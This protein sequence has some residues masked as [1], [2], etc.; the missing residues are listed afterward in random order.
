MRLAGCVSGELGSKDL[1]TV[2][3][4]HFWKGLVLKLVWTHFGTLMTHC[5]RIFTLF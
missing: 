5:V 2:D 4:E 3:L 1:K